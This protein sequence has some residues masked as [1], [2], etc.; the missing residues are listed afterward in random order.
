MKVCVYINL[1]K[2]FKKQSKTLL[3]VEKHFI[4]SIINKGKLAICCFLKDFIFSSCS[5]NQIITY[6]YGSKKHS[7]SYM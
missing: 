6:E 4:F 1:I 5:L 3:H 7:K 2:H